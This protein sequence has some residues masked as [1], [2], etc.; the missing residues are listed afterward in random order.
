MDIGYARIGRAMPLD[1]GGWGVVG[2][3]M[4]P[5]RLLAELARRHPD[6]RFIITSLCRDDPASAGLP[7]NVVNSWSPARLDWLRERTSK[8]R[9]S[10]KYEDLERRTALFDEL[11]HPVYEKLDAIIVWLGQHGTSNSRIPTVSDRGAAED[12]RTKPQDSFVQ[13]AGHVL[14][15]IN[16]WREVD[17]LRREEVW[18][19][20]DARNYIKGRDLKWPLRHPILGQYD[21]SRREH[22]ERYG[23]PRQPEECGFEGVTW[24]TDHTWN[25]ETRYVYSQLEVC[26]ITPEH[27]DTRY[28]E[29]HFRRSHFGL[30]INEA[31]SYVKLNRRDIVREWVLPLRPAFIHGQ[32]SDQSQRSIGTVVTPAP[33]EDYFDKLRSVLCTFTTPSSGSGWL[34]TKPWEA[35]AVG[36]V[37]FFHP[38]YDTQDHA[39][40]HAPAELKEWLRVPTP[41]DLHKRVVTLW[42]DP[43]A[44][45]WIVREQRKLYDLAMEERRWMKMIEE[46]VWV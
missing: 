9:L 41:L 5:P 31:R 35:F 27:C 26:G 14:R 2:G 22:N 30:F 45:L 11:V 36:T 12:G 17:P 25:A 40:E 18:L 13:Y 24:S 7:S 29:T 42:N 28:D 33:W 8:L 46:R 39:F 1:S 21:W 16:H 23:D 10:D 4:E 15:G 19:I 34:T 38:A 3:D 32:W 43:A 37:C 20:A 6:D 44:W